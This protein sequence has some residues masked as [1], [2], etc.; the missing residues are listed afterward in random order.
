MKSKLSVRCVYDT[1]HVY[2]LRIENTSESDPRSY[3]ATKWVV[4]KEAHT[5]LCGFNGIQTHDL[6]DT[7]AMLNQLSY[8]ALLVV[9]PLC[10]TL[11][12]QQSRTWSEK[13]YNL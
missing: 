9:C 4:A 1:D 10:L 8:E 3:E 12:G 11:L 2:V 7:G 5:K 13:S 6:G